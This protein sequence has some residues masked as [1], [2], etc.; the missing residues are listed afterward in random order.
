MKTASRRSARTSAMAAPI[1]HMITQLYTL[2]PMCFES[3]SAG[4]ETKQRILQISGNNWRRLHKNK[5]SPWRVSQ[6]KNAP[7]IYN[8]KFVS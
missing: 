5:Y 8:K 4:I 7:K 1:V 3:L 6:A 2:S